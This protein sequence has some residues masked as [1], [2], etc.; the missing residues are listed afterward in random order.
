MG[1][2]FSDLQR[3]AE[4]GEETM[5]RPK[6]AWRCAKCAHP[7]AEVGEARQSGSALASVFDLEGLRFTT[8]S[9]RRCGYTEF[10]KADA[11]MLA[12]LFDFGVG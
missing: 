3:A 5:Q 4:L 10:Y 7:I 12:T 6:D 11:G 2:G 1:S 9:C 8:V